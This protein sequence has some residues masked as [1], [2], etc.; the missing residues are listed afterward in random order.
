MKMTT[1]LELLHKAEACTGRYRHLR[2][3]LGMDWPQNRDIDLLQVLELNGLQDALWALKAVKQ[4][5][6]REARLMAADFTE[7]VLPQWL[8]QYPEDTRVAKCI[9]GVRAYANGNITWQKLRVLRD[10]ADD[11]ANDAY[12]VYVAAEAA[13]YVAAADDAYAVYTAAADDA[14]AAYAAA[15]AAA[16]AAADVAVDAVYAAADKAAD[17]AATAKAAAAATAYAAAAVAAKAATL[18]ERTRIFVSHLQD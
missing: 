6:Q 16:A 13:V 3:A 2:E 12:A 4:D 11:A 7:S 8:V 17:A 15:E 1:T 5:I 18:T 10:A 9:E 14:Y